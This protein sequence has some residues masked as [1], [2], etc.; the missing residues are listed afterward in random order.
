MTN[1]IY[2]PQFIKD[3]IANSLHN[4]QYVRK[5][6]YYTKEVDTWLKENNLTPT[7]II[8]KSV[9]MEYVYPHI[10]EVCGK[11]ISIYNKRWGDIKNYCSREC[12]NIGQQKKYKETCL[13]KYGVV[14]TFQSPE[15]QQRARKTCLEKYGVEFPIQLDSVKEKLKET[16]LKKYGVESPNQSEIVKQHKRESCLKKY[17]VDYTLS[18]ESVKNKTKETCLKKYG[19]DNISKLTTTVDKIKETFR[20]G[21]FDTFLEKI[22][23]KDFTLLTPYEEYPT[24]NILKFRCN[25][26]GNEWTTDR[27]N[28]QKIFCTS[29]FQSPDSKKEKDFFEYIKSIYDGEVIRND[30]QVLSDYKMELDIYIP[31]LKLGFEFNGTYWHNSK[32]KDRLYHQRKTK[33]CSENGIR[34]VHIYEY[35]W[36]FK[37]EKIKE[38]IKHLF[39]IYQHKVYA[40]NC[41]VKEIDNKVYRNFLDNHHLQDSVNSSNRYG[42]FYKDELVSVIG[43]GKS[44]FKNNEIELHRYCVKSGYLIVGGFSKL[45]KHSGIE[46]FVSYIDYNHYTGAGYFKIGFKF[47]NLTPPNYVYVKNNVILSRNQTQ[48]HKL[49]DILEFYDESLTETQN[50][51]REH[52]NKIYDAGNI[53]VIYECHK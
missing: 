47:E 50:M 6:R 49:K 10:C 15:L 9:N 51:I 31:K 7:Y 34:L 45:I 41:E 27:S 23:D 43:F 44:R 24:T 53:K 42:L 28:P 29:C 3:F 8:K 33:L 46:N 48:K 12:K 39:G 13:E 18:L 25:I 40:R 14:N 4:G 16:S 26:C 2:I 17:G 36:D 5:I 19:V 38:Y 35:E 37:T 22:N 30:R 32:N 20:K 21:Y 52:W 1:R 11:E